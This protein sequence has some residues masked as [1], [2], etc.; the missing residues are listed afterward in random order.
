MLKL[1]FLLM[2]GIPYYMCKLAIMLLA[3]PIAWIWA[4]IVGFNTSANK[5]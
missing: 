3:A 4:F 1:L 5:R 2:F